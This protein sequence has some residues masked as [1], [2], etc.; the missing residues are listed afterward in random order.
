MRVKTSTFYNIRAFKS[1]VQNKFRNKKIL[2]IGINDRKNSNRRKI[3]KSFNKK[4]SQ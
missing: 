2:R 1:A 3:T 4:I